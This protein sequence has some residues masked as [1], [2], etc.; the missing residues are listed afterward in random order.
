M[1][2]VSRRVTERIIVRTHDR[3]IVI[4]FAGWQGKKARIGIEAPA[5]VLVNR[6]EIQQQIDRRQEIFESLKGGV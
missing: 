4:T 5:D 6:E 1:L 3:E 2:V